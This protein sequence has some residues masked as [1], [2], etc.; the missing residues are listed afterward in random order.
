MTATDE[1]IMA[2]IKDYTARNGYPPSMREL[3]EAVGIASAGSITYRL[4][5]LRERG[6]VAF[7]DRKARTM[8]VIV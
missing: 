7:D 6:M 5:K 2:A 8:R 1:Q 4:R 3:C